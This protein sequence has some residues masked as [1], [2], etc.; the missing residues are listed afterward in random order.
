MQL[1]REYA[2]LLRSEAREVASMLLPILVSNVLIMAN[3]LITTMWVGRMGEVELAGA[4]LG[5]MS[6]SI[7][8]SAVI[9]LT[10][11]VDTLGSQAYGAGNTHR[12]GVAM[13]RGMAVVL[14]LALPLA[15]LFWHM[16]PVLLAARQDPAVARLSAQYT[17]CLALCLVPAFFAQQVAHGLA[18]A[19]RTAPML[20]LMGTATCANAACAWLLVGR[21]GVGFVGAPAALALG[22]ALSL[23]ACV[24]FALASGAFDT[25]WP[26]WT[27]EALAE[28]PQFLG[29][30]VPGVLMVCA[31]WVAFEVC[32][33]VAGSVDARELAAFSLL[34]QTT[35]CL[36]M[37]PMSF[38]MC[39][40]TRVG[41][42]LGAGDARRAR[43]AACV[44]LAGAA[45][46]L[47]AC[48]PPLVAC[49]CSWGRV[50]TTDAAVVGAV[51]RGV[52]V[53][54]AM[55]ALD[56]VQTVESGVLRGAGLQRFGALC[57]VVFYYA[58][59]LPLACVAAL[60]L[61]W[62]A[63]GI[64]VAMSLGVLL[65]ALT[66]TAKLCALDWERV[67]EE[68]ARREMKLSDYESETDYNVYS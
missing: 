20:A 24:L 42:S 9:G 36:F 31:D 22:H 29:L 48:L 51:A 45:A 19:G 47:G 3:T 67:A 23:P 17:R 12:V 26:G 15:L 14:A 2:P 32:A 57:N 16:R 53:V 49:R 18:S 6:M 41:N 40:C 44:C 13:Q 68:V 34:Y 64:F 50:F 38:G 8:M 60:R 39:A 1:L 59:G 63:W 27:A 62:G 35:G 66:F 4:A 10:T 56:C 52:P 43:A 28:L 25:L 37:V 61:R 65:Q 21:L 33:L 55:E 7:A 30:A 46:A 5:S 54:A 11:A 58:V